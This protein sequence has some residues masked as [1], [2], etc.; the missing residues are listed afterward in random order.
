MLINFEVATINI[1][2]GINVFKM[3]NNNFT[4]FNFILVLLYFKFFNSIRLI[5]KS[6]SYLCKSLIILSIII[7]YTLELTLFRYL[8][9]KLLIEV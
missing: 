3:M 8:Q 7:S 4:I 2:I 5:K 9:I 1:E 6:N